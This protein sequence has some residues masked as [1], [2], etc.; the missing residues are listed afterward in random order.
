MWDR[1]RKTTFP[2]FVPG[3]SV[4]APAQ[5][6]MWKLHFLLEPFAEG[7]QRCK[8]AHQALKRALHGLTALAVLKDPTKCS[9]RKYY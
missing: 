6:Q 8:L 2:I 5:E 3:V 7:S 9:E 1:V 4:A